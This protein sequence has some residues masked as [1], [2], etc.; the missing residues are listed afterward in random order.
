MPTTE[1]RRARRLVRVALFCGAVGLLATA[2]VSTVS[3]TVVDQ[4][5]VELRRE[6]DRI[7][8]LDAL[9]ADVLMA[10]SEHRAFLLDGNPATHER[11][12]AAERSSFLLLDS[13]GAP[14]LDDPPFQVAVAALRARLDSSAAAR[15][16][17][18]DARALSPALAVAYFSD[19]ASVRFR[20]RV[21]SA[22]FDLRT[23]GTARLADVRARWETAVLVQRWASY[24]TLVV[25]G[26]GVAALLL[27]LRRETT[28]TAVSEA[29]YVA[30]TDESPDGIIVQVNGEVRYANRAV[31]ELF[32]VPDGVSLVGRPFFDLV[33]PDERAESRKRARMVV[34]LDQPA[35]PRVRRFLRDDGTEMEAEIRGVRV[36]FEGA[37][38]G[39]M[40]IRDIHDREVAQRALEASE[41]RYRALLADMAEG[42][43]LADASLVT[44]LWNP[45]AERILGLT[46]DQMAGR[47]SYD[48]QWAIVDEHGTPMPVQQRFAATA[49]RTG[50]R[51]TGIMGV[52]RP[53]GSRVWAYVSAVPLRREGADEP[54]AVEIT[55][56]DITAEREATRKIS[57]SEAKYR[58]LAE[59][60]ADLISRR[61]LHHRF[62]YV[63]PSH[64]TLLGWTAEEMLGRSVKEFMHPD[65]IERLSSRF[66]SVA[67]GVEA[68]TATIRVRHKDGHYL[69]LEG[70]TKPVLNDAGEAIG[71]QVSA[72]DITAR[73]S[74]EEQLRQSQKLEAMGRMASGVAHDFNNL[75]TVMRASSEMLED[76][77]LDESDRQVVQR[78]ILTAIE[79]ATALTAQLL[80]FS[81]GRHSAPEHVRVASLLRNVSPLLSRLCGD[82]L[83]VDV[84]VQPNATH[85][86]IDAEVVQVEQVLFNLVVNARDA[87]PD[88]GRIEVRCGTRVLREPQTHA[89][90]IVHPGA[91]VTIE[92]QDTGNGMS[93]EVQAHVFEPFFTTKPQGK[94][95]GLGLSTVFG[96]VKQANGAITLESA[97]GHGCTVTVFWPML[98]L[99]AETPASVPAIADRSHDA[100]AEPAP[101][102]DHRPILV[103]DDEP[104]VGAMI[105]RLLGRIGFT[106]AVETS[107]FAALDL[108][109]QN[110][111]GFRMLI[112]DVRM[113]HLSGIELVRRLIES[114]IDIPVLFVSAQLDGP[115]PSDWPPQLTYRFLSKPF[116][117]DALSHEV[118][119]LTPTP[120]A[121][122]A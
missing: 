108:L 80:A 110:P 48:P 6:H 55:F 106:V 1:A 72:R 23:R 114:G 62:E 63:S 116:T 20:L 17:S 97:V 46:S 14:T 102:H 111:T 88:G 36:I 101:L 87:M 122:H 58:L 18:A 38:A 49:L 11:Y 68:S 113:P 91:Y 31:R 25:L 52:D 4:R 84:R 105:G 43:I 33:H 40:V 94:G 44:Q 89:H 41:H 121:S 5:L 93:D 34:D 21:D 98:S 39:Q 7:D 117:I 57:E 59:N 22:L 69:W 45:A 61:S 103:V 78:E 85:A 81:R 86:M 24:G 51:A 54:Y 95:T 66:R 70:V 92:V 109:R 107:A 74:L 115:F 8:R 99:S 26:L 82:R 79:R 76:V 71:Y 56:S 50:Q 65:D 118:A 73:H 16:R 9:R 67:Q 64:H 60:S 15:K 119:E 53:D 77:T 100:G 12:L 112:T 13:L 47:S 96:I 37:P 28:Q 90:G 83:T 120:T 30:L 104:I 35:A 42:V 19:P 29:R 32:R 27:T 3:V 10:R 75:L 2:T